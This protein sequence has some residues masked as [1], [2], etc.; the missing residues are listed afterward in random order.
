MNSRAQELIPIGACGFR[1]L[2]RWA[3]ALAKQTYPSGERR[4]EEVG[5]LLALA[6][7]CCIPHVLCLDSGQVEPLLHVESEA[8]HWM[9]VCIYR[10]DLIFLMFL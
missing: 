6:S 2:E 3:S 4:L 7:A 10:A 5:L 1:M 9:M 8:T